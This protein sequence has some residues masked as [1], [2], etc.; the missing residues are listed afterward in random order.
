MKH[1]FLKNPT[2]FLHFLLFSTIFSSKFGKRKTLESL[3][4]QGFSTWSHLW[5]S[6]PRP[7]DYKTQ[8]GYHSALLIFTETHCF[9]RFAST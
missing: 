3:N 8:P 5:D 7:A 6:N 1:V 2:L 4:F 9:Q